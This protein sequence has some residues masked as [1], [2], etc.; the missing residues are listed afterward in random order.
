[1]ASSEPFG[2]DQEA[3]L[4]PGTPQRDFRQAEQASRDEH[5]RMENAAARRAQ[6]GIQRPKLR[7]SIRHWYRWLTR[8]KPAER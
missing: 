1:M 8:R 6:L 4:F 5:A 2:E 3:V 7:E